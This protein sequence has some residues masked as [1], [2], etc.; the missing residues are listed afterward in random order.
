MINEQKRRLQRIIQ[1]HEKRKA[2]GDSEDQIE[3][4]PKPEKKA[5]RMPVHRQNRKA[6]ASSAPRKHST[7][8]NKYLPNHIRQLE[9]ENKHMQLSIQNLQLKFQTQQQLQ[10]M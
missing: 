7:G 1:G 5:I 6:G 2:A 8:S 10:Q 9:E 3:V 4:G